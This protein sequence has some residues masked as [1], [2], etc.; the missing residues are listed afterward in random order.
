MFGE[1]YVIPLKATLQDIEDHFMAESVCLPTTDEVRGWVKGRNRVRP[2]SP[3][4]LRPCG[5]VSIPTGAA[6]GGMNP[7]TTLKRK[8]STFMKDEPHHEVHELSSYGDAPLIHQKEQTKPA[9]STRRKAKLDTAQD[10]HKER[11]YA[12]DMNN[13][14]ATRCQR[15]ASAA[16]SSTIPVPASDLLALYSAAAKVAQSTRTPA[17]FEPNNRSHSTA[18]SALDILRYDGQPC[19]SNDPW[20]ST[21]PAIALNNFNCSYVDPDFPPGLDPFNSNHLSDQPPGRSG[22]QQPCSS[23]T[24][25]WSEYGACHTPPLVAESSARRRVRRR[26]YDSGY[27]SLLQTR[28]HSENASPEKWG[29]IMSSSS[30]PLPDFGELFGTLSG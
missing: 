14:F 28:D 9:Q 8:L 3:A 27:S 25:Q 23:R 11:I 10:P 6:W 19:G 12:G 29:A 16:S 13:D 30:V 5:T 7:S 2:A 26:G 21:V 22:H 18:P 17:I 15:P 1:A 24:S 4:F 20:T